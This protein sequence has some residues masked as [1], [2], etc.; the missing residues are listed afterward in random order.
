MLSS[1]SLLKIINLKKTTS[2]KGNSEVRYQGWLMGVEPTTPASTV[3]CSAIEL[4]PP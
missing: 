2:E 1:L 4:Q 3:R